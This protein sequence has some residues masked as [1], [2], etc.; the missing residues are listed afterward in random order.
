MHNTIPYN[1]TILKWARERI[2]YTE[3]DIAKKFSKSVEDIQSWEKGESSPTYLQLE[4]LAYEIYKKPLAVF[5]FPAPPTHVNINKSFRT[6]AEYE[7]LELEPKFKLLI[8]KAFSYQLNIKDLTNNINPSTGFIL[9]NLSFNHKDSTLDMVESLRN[10]LDISINEQ[11]DWKSTTKALESWTN[12]LEE[13]G[14]FVFKE[15]F[16]NENYSGFCLYDDNIPIIYINNSKS[17]SRQIFTLFHEL[18]HL[19]F[20]TSGIDSKNYFDYFQGP[21]EIIERHCNQFAGEFLIPTSSFEKDI[22][23]L[24]INDNTFNNLAKNYSVSKEA[25]LRKYLNLKLVSTKYYEEKRQQWNHEYLELKKIRKQ[26]GGPKPYHKANTYLS[27]TYKDLV[28][29]NYLNNN[30]SIEQA[31][32]L[33]NIKSK[34]FKPLIQY[35]LGKEI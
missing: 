7:F 34:Y 19:L 1:P 8:D 35:Y 10:F 20:N 30:L 11:K 22:Q 5:F 16:K 25:I 6:I 13:V 29:Q 14:I 23:N 17:K 18:A 27:N 3:E 15:A 4:R 12:K 31:S 2:N 32:N 24:K 9:N 26:T 28:I 33:F 21:E